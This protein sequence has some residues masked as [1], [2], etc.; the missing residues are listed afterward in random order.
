MA[1]IAADIISPEKQF[2]SRREKEPGVS[3]NHTLFSCGMHLTIDS[4][5]IEK[6]TACEF[7]RN[8]DTLKLQSVLRLFNLKKATVIQNGKMGNNAG[9]EDG[10]LFKALSLTDAVSRSASFPGAVRSDG[11]K[12]QNSRPPR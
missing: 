7:N 6:Q 5:T 9:K 2:V 12:N 10:H 4:M 3:G 1:A 11:S 8:I